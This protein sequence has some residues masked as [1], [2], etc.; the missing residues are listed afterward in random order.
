[1]TVDVLVLLPDGTTRSF[2]N[3]TLSMRLHWI[4]I[5][6][7]NGDETTL[8]FRAW[9]IRETVPE[10]VKIRKRDGAILDDGARV[11]GNFEAVTIQRRRSKKGGGQ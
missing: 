8:N 4:D 5:R 11:T 1:M 3:V 6:D 10:K 2:P 9:S 7:K